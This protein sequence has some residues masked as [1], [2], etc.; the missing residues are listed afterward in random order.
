MKK[1]NKVFISVCLAVILVFLHTWQYIHSDYEVKALV[2]LIVS[3]L[4]I[5]I[6]LIF[7]FNALPIFLACYGFIYIPFESFD[8]Y[9]SL[10]LICS[11]ISLDKRLK[12]LIWIYCVETFCCYMSKGLQLSHIGIT[13]CYIVFI[14]NVF[15]V[16]QN[17]HS[18]IEPLL[19]TDDE[20]HILEQLL[21]GKEI[22]EVTGF[23]QNTIYKKL[24]SARERNACITNDELLSRYKN[25]KK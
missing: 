6:I 10:L 16:I 24:R 21:L 22:K 25:T 3:V 8:N 5:P 15:L 4:Y 20:K 13:M 11:A 12:S 7:K 17:K 9:T 1:D 14:W 18:E 19:I 2:N 23:S